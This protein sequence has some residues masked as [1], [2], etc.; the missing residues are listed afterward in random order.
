MVA[1]AVVV[2]GAAREGRGVGVGG[3][4]AWR[5]AWVVGRQAVCVAAVPVGSAAVVALVAAVAA[6]AGAE[7]RADGKKIA[8]S[9]LG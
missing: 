8:R 3:V 5:V 2:P 1:A 6:A 7:P 4:Q 9:S